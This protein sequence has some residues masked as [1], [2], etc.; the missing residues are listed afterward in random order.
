MRKVYFLMIML[1]LV[2]ATKVYAYSDGD[3]QVWN[4]DIQD[5]KVNKNLKAVLEEEFRWGGNSSE[6]YYHHYDAGLFYSLNKYWNLGGGY[7][8]VYEL[9]KGKF[10]LENEPYMTAAVSLT[11]NGY[12]LE[13]RNRLE[14]R[15]FDYQSDSWRYRNKFTL[16]FP[17]K[18]TK[19]EIQPYAADEIYVK[20]GSGIG[21]FNQNRASS[22]FTMNLSANLKAEIY[23]ML[24][25]AKSSGKWNDTNVLGTKLKLSF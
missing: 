14:Y 17:W 22:G 24:V 10:K 20:F 16:K 7:R 12:T 1:A 21:Q 18:L 19:M 15:H 4:T 25:S 3:F 5:F 13:S 8:H 2:L 9:S 11:K 23:Y 6:F